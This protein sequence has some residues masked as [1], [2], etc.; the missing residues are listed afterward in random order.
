MP[1]IS[2]FF[3]LL[4]STGEKVDPTSV[5]PVPTQA[6]TNVILQNTRQAHTVQNT[7]PIVVSEVLSPVIETP[8]T[9]QHTQLCTPQNETNLK[10]RYSEH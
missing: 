7:P 10:V 9:Q 1:H 2:H 4:F 3:H 8:V 6:C 5:F